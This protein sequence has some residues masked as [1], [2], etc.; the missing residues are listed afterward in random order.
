M[1]QQKKSRKCRSCKKPLGNNHF[2][3]DEKC[4]DE[5]NNQWFKEIDELIIVEPK[6]E[7]RT[8]PKCVGCEHSCAITF[9]D[10]NYF[11]INVACRKDD[12][13]KDIEEELQRGVTGANLPRVS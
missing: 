11:P 8:Y 3:C 9:Y 12:D 4:I 6:C 2:F 1:K 10:R 7:V 13:F 5:F